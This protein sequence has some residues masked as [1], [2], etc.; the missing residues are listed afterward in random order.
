MKKQC[1]SF[2]I[3]TFLFL[4]CL[5]FAASS[6]QESQTDPYKLYGGE[7]GNV[8]FQRE[9]IK[10]V[11]MAAQQIDALV[12]HCFKKSIRLKNLYVHFLVGKDMKGGLAAQRKKIAQDTK[13]EDCELFGKPRFGTCLKKGEVQLHV[14]PIHNDDKPVW[15]KST[16]AFFQDCFKNLPHEVAEKTVD[17]GNGEKYDISV[18]FYCQLLDQLKRE[19]EKQT[20]P[21]T[22]QTFQAEILNLELLTTKC[23]PGLAVLDLHQALSQ[24]N[25]QALRIQLFYKNCPITTLYSWVPGDTSNQYHGVTEANLSRICKTSGFMA[26]HV[27]YDTPNFL[28]EDA[29]DYWEKAILWTKGKDQLEQLKDFL[30]RHHYLDSHAMPFDRGSDA[31]KIWVLQS[32]VKYHSNKKGDKL[33][34][35]IADRPNEASL[36]EKAIITPTIEQYVMYFKKRVTLRP[37]K[38]E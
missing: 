31:V 24:G 26:R 29:A 28:L 22:I 17:Q 13:T 10:V 15:H 38:S 6:M 16:G 25:L 32:I 3:S 5:S 19:A 11:D 35:V 12:S 21:I 27:E 2:N 33:E 20:N 9:S 18:I 4:T 37:L 36:G 1:I 14:T 8:I 23:C 7:A 34:L 30:A